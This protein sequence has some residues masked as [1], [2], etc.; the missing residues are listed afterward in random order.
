[1]TTISLTTI[2][3]GLAISLIVMAAVLSFLAGFT[4]AT[5]VDYDY[6]TYEKL[7]LKYKLFAYV[8]LDIIAVLITVSLL[9]MI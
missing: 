3:L 8:V 9:G 6:S 1:M 7:N 2:S 4:T 5:A